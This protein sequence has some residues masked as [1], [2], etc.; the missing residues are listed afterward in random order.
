MQQDLLQKKQ[1][2]IPDKYAI[3]WTDIEII[4]DSNGRPTINLNS[5]NTENIESIDISISHCKEYA[6]AN[7]VVM[8]KK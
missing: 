7:V 3:E 8:L 1:Y 6:T 5:I 2:L 4:N